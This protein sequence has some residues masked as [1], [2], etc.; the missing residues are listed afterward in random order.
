MVLRARAAAPTFSGTA[1]STSTKCSMDEPS[2]FLI[3]AR[4]DYGADGS[5]A[6]CF[7]GAVVP[8]RFPAGGQY[9]QFEL[10]LTG[11][12]FQRGLVTPFVGF[13]QT[14]VPFGTAVTGSRGSSNDIRCHLR[15]ARYSC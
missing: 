14:H 13:I 15:T 6:P 5:G 4:F 12:A 3:M 9:F 8:A 2:L 7:L 1:G 10:R 11:L